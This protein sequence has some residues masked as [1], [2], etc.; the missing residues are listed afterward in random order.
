VPRWQ[1]FQQHIEIITIFVQFSTMNEA[2]QCQTGVN[3][4]RK[5][6]V[7]RV[8]FTRRHLFQTLTNTGPSIK[9]VGNDDEIAG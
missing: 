2:P 3:I 6:G 5:A 1:T 8:L 4:T 9:E 7:L